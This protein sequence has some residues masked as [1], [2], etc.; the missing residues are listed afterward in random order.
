MTD[1][2]EA[3]T[4]AQLVAL[5]RRRLGLSCGVLSDLCDLS[6]SYIA[7]FESGRISQPSLVAFARMARA[8]EMTPAEV[9]MAVMVESR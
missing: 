6:H 1:T 8:L 3:L 5:K 4:A 9:Y 2:I 7:K